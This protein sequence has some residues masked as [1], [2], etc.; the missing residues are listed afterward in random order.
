MLRR[1]HPIIRKWF[2]D[3]LGKPSDPQRIGWPAIATGEHTLILAPT[4]TGK[5]LAAFLWELNALIVAGLKEPLG[6]AV[7]LLYISLIKPLP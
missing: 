1:F 7:H 3:R 5:A 4:G 2:A 6:N